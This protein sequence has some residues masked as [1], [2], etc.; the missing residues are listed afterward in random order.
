MKLYRT[1]LFVKCHFAECLHLFIVRLN[2]IMLNV[3]MLSIVILNVVMLNAIILNVV[4][5]NVTMLS[6][7]MLNVVAPS[8]LLTIILKASL[9]VVNLKW[10]HLVSI[11]T[12]KCN[13]WLL[14]KITQQP[15]LNLITKFGRNFTTTFMSSRAF[16]FCEQFS[17]L[18]WNG[19]AYSK[20]HCKFNV[21]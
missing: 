6:I 16:H 11:F 8:N 19:L 14:L 5:L 18:L 7:V 17:S 20:V 3:I 15:L 10:S 9:A 13:Y 1:V 21:R 2:V 4:M 12:P